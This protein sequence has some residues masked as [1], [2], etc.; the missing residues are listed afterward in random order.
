MTDTF[1]ER[2]NLLKDFNLSRKMINF[3][4]SKALLFW[5]VASALQEE[6]IGPRK[7]VVTVQM[8]NSKGGYYGCR[9]ET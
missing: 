3:E 5:K 7:G 4:F 6:R 8:G 9:N 1:S 2:G